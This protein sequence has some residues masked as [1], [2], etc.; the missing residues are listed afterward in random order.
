M[1]LFLF[2]ACNGPAKTD[3]TATDDTATDDTRTADDTATDADDTAAG[4]DDTTTAGPLGLDATWDGKTYADLASDWWRWVLEEPVATNPALD[5]TGEHCD[6][7]QDGTVWRL[8]ANLSPTPVFRT[9]TIPADRALFFPIL[10]GYADNAGVPKE[11]QMTEEEM[12][13]YLTSGL[14]TAEDMVVTLDGVA[15]GEPA[16]YL[17]GPV[18]FTYTVPEDDSLYDAY[19]MDV[20]GLVD[21]AYH[22]GYWNLLA[23]LEAG[24]HTLRFEGVLTFDPTTDADDFAVLAEYT[25]TVE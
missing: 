19:G 21:P 6:V 3:D 23:P 12:Q 15:I 1:H 22:V 11:S 8:G 13:D 14:A 16:D 18:P 7:G 17:V 5:A 2:L 10:T 20:S 25:L 4:T 9:C 24:E